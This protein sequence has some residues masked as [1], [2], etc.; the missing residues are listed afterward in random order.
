MGRKWGGRK[1]GQE[2]MGTFYFS[3]AWRGRPRGCRLASSPRRRAIF[4]VHASLPNGA[5]RVTLPRRPPLSQ[6]RPQPVLGPGHQSG[7]QGIA[8]NVAQ[9]GE[10]MHILLNRERLTAPLP[11]MPA[12][13]VGAVI[14]ADVRRQQPLHPAAQVLIGPGPDRHMKVGRH[15]AVPEHPH[16]HSGGARA[17]QLHEGLI[18]PRLAKDLGPGVAPVEHV[19]TETPHSGACGA[20]H[21]ATVRH[22][23]V[24]G[25]RKVECPLYVIR[26]HWM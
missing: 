19:I 12:A 10:Q 4:T 3:G 21:G 5:P 17:Q 9:D 18:V 24:R 22:G 11:H 16:R 25:K 26:N 15:Q 14:P 23:G 8:L 13:A 2:E 7:P 6:T 20:R 1:W